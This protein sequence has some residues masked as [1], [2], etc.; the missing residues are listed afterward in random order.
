MKHHLLGI[1]AF[2]PL[3]AKSDFFFFFFPLMCEAALQNSETVISDL[4]K[5]T[6]ENWLLE[7]SAYP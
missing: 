7:I 2:A 3:T 6:E 1:N 4:T 5:T